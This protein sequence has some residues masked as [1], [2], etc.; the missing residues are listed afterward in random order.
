MKNLRRL[1][2]T[3]AFL[4]SSASFLG[5]MELVPSN[6][7]PPVK[8]EEDDALR[9]LK[10]DIINLEAYMRDAV[11]VGC[12]I[13]KMLDAKTKELKEMFLALEV[14][15]KPSDGSK[16]LEALK[17]NI[18]ECWKLVRQKLQKEIKEKNS[19]AL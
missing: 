3:S 7:M 19:W 15:K 1:F 8:N 16:S 2:L 6:S 17:E 5:A 11:P 4:L 18:K 14:E 13:W 10:N 9:S 12:A